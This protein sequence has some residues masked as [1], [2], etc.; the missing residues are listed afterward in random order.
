MDFFNCYEYEE[1]FLFYSI[2]N[3]FERYWS[4]ANE[5]TDYNPYYSNF[6]GSLRNEILNNPDRYRYEF[7]FMVYLTLYHTF[8]NNQWQKIDKIKQ[9]LFYIYKEDKM[10]KKK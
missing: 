2:Y 9:F 4:G 6:Y 7:P 10:Y 3:E 1:K 5:K 8:R